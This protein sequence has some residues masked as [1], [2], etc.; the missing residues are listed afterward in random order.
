MLFSSSTTF[1]TFTSQTSGAD[2]LQAVGNNDTIEVALHHMNKITTWHLPKTAPT[3]VLYKLANRATHAKFSSFVLRCL[4]STVQ[5]ADS[6]HLTIGSTL[7]GDEGAIK[8]HRGVVHSRR[9][10]VITVD[11]EHS[12]AQTII[13]PANASILALISHI[14]APDGCRLSDIML[15][16]DFLCR[17]LSGTKYGQGMVSR[18]QEMVSVEGKLSILNGLFKVMLHRSRFPSNVVRGSGIQLDP[19]KVERKV[20]IFLD[21]IC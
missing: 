6:T 17:Q 16:Y 18:S 9:P 7:L 10:Q 4:H 13:L 11:F 15:W 3:R 12:E 21:W 8:I 14:R 2:I 19:R 20:D 1:L 5:I